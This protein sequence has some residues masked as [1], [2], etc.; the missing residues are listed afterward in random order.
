MD[1]Y[2]IIFVCVLL[3]YS[4]LVTGEVYSIHSSVLDTPESSV[5]PTHSELEIAREIISR[6]VSE[7]LAHVAADI[8]P[9]TYVIPACGGS[10]WRRVAFLDMTDPNQICPEQ[11]R[12]YDQDGV[13]AC[14]RQESL[15]SSCSS[16]NFSSNEYAYTQVCGRV[17]A[18]QFASPD[19]GSDDLGLTP[20]D[21]INGPYVDGV[22]ITYGF[23][24]QH[25][26]SLFGSLYD[27]FCCNGHISNH[28]FVGNNFFCDTG[29]PVSGLFA[30]SLT[31]LVTDYPLWDGNTQCPNNENCCAPSSGPW[32][33]ALL[34]SS[35]MSDIEVRICG[36]QQSDDE[37]TPVELMEI[38]VK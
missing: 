33:T 5:C 18:Y 10:G 29:N 38:Y 24:R 28:D 25:I 12:L 27:I 26:W 4:S 15:G 35:S 7:I 22:S 11:W 37:D 34:S 20:G 13:R 9:V 23:P 30:W 16:A 17:T 1:G 31:S 8:D 21:E 19:G 2:F 14:G 3:S 36:D 6:N 32:F